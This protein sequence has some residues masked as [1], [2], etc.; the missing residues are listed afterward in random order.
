MN[1]YDT[2]LGLLQLAAAHALRPP[3]APSH[4]LAVPE[5]LAGSA[6]SSSP[7]HVVSA[8]TEEE[9]ESTAAYLPCDVDSSDAPSSRRSAVYNAP[10]SFCGDIGGQKASSV[11]KAAAV[12][13][14][15]ASARHGGLLV[16]PVDIWSYLLGNYILP[17]SALALRLSCRS[18]NSIVVSSCWCWE[19]R[20]PPVGLLDASQESELGA[21]CRVRQWSA[22]AMA[23]NMSNDEEDE[24]LMLR[25]AALLRPR[26][27]EEFAFSTRGQ[28]VPHN[29]C[30][31]GCCY[32]AWL[33]STRDEI[34]F[35]EQEAIAM[36]AFEFAASMAKSIFFP[37]DAGRVRTTFLTTCASLSVGATAVLQFYHAAPKVQQFIPIWV[38]FGLL[39]PLLYIFF[40]QTSIETLVAAF[41][42]TFGVLLTVLLHYFYRDNDDAVM[43]L[44]S[45]TTPTLLC[46]A[47][48]ATYAVLLC[49]RWFNSQTRRSVRVSVL[50]VA[51]AGVPTLLL[52]SLFLFAAQGDGMIQSYGEAPKTGRHAK[53]DIATL[54]PQTGAMPLAIVSFTLLA[55]IL[56]M[57]GTL[58]SRD[59]LLS[60]PIAV[61]S[62][63]GYCLASTALGVLSLMLFL[64]AEVWLIVGFGLAI[65]SMFLG[66]TIVNALTPKDAERSFSH[67]LFRAHL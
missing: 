56:H 38:F 31:D 19:F 28:M 47:S 46:V 37:A 36:E 67:V 24:F 5:Q 6:T 29:V 66:S 13:V 9:L 35:L 27:Q 20:L 49:H 7:W 4:P 34:A 44:M 2:E 59:L 57:L 26:W 64:G 43:S 15:V 54:Q 53:N 33:R 60:E 45:C 52:V 42:S 8:A 39:F 55:D 11:E 16:L 21:V 25:M 41:I 22:K 62:L 58:V 40:S 32:R 63:I 51:T 18:L 65:V 30:H 1:I 61:L 10:I 48:L 23:E 14:A 3:A 50:A 17:G 12:T